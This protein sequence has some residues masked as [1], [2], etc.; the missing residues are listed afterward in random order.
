MDKS[1]RKVLVV[2]DDRIN[3]KAISEALKYEFQIMAATNAEQAL[4]AVR[5]EAPPDLVLLDV[6]MPGVDG[7]EVCRRIKSHTQSKHIHVIFITSM[8]GDTDEAK[9]L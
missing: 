4:R 7:F 1:K 6:M 9:G 3:I 2:D 5:S 8:D